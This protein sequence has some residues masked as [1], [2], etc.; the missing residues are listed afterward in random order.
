MGVVGVPCD[1]AVLDPPDQGHFADSEMRRRI[2]PRQQPAPPEPVVAGSEP[3]LIGEIGDAQCGES[4]VGL[5]STC[6]TAGMDSS[7]VQNVGDFGV[8]VIV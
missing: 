1:E 4:S 2:L 6:R 5:A 7:I 3:V 8:D